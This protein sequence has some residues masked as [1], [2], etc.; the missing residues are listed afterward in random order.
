[1]SARGCGGIGSALRE[2]K[3]GLMVNLGLCLFALPVAVSA[4]QVSVAGIMGE[5]A[6]L[7]VEGGPPKVLRAGESHAGVRLLEVGP[8][9]VLIELNGRRH[10]LAVGQGAYTRTAAPATGRGPARVV[11]TADARGHFTAEGLVNGLGVQFLVD[12]GASLVSLPMSLARRAGVNLAT[13]QPVVINTAN[14][15][16]R[17]QRVVLDSLKVGDIQAHLV[18]ALVV[19]DAQL[20]QPLLGMSFLNRTD[21]LRE[22]DTLVLTQRY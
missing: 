13:G 3:V 11:I 16:T 2:G 10:R 7:S 22:G 4:T 20:A 18:E 5:R 14:G 21:L 19:E 6:A 1:M 9:G 17:A 8:E 12:T 15:R